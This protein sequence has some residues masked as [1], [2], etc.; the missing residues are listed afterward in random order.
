LPSNISRVFAVPG[1]VILALM[2]K[3]RFA[4]RVA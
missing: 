3:H 2:R 4:G 1:K